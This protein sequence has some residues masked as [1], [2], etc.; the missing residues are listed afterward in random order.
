M[1]EEME[2]MKRI[3]CVAGKGL[4]DWKALKEAADA[5]GGKAY[6]V[7]RKYSYHGSRLECLKADIKYYRTI[8]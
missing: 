1:L 4:V 5:N 2:R 6:I 3:N 8:I 7:E